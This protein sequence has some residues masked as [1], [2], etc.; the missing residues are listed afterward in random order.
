MKGTWLQIIILISFSLLMI[1]KVDELKHFKPFFRAQ[2][3]IKLSNFAV[4]K[5]NVSTKD[6]DLIEL[7]ESMLTGRSAPVS[8]WIKD[9]YKILGLNHLFTPSGFH[10]SAVML[11]L[12]KVVK[13]K[14]YQMAF[15]LCIAFGVFSMNGQ[16]A[17]KRMVLIKINQKLLGQ[18]AGFILALLID[19]LFGSFTDLPLSFCYSFLFLG[20]IYSGTSWMFLW[21]FFGQCLIS[22]FNGVHISPLIMVLSPILN[23][24]FGLAM[25]LLFI[26]AIPLWHWQMK[27]GLIILELLQNLV[28]LSAHLSSLLPF[29]EVN[30]ATLLCFLLFYLRRRYLLATLILVFSHSLN[31]DLNKNPSFGSYEFVPRGKILRV[32][33]NEKGEVVY[34]SDGKCKR[35][36]VRGIWWEK[37]SPKRRRSTRKNKLKK[38][39]SV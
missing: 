22:Y 13:D 33:S 7:W 2:K 10:L 38:L 32:V 27:I 11:P 23:L 31:L 29:W 3:T 25:P 12:M 35:E 34:W 26:L 28:E 24:A 17:L 14:K 39:S 16:G 15:L 8:K 30:I 20:I 6:A 18:K 5:K 36:L 4:A 21:F 1:L 19:V 37:C 9:Q